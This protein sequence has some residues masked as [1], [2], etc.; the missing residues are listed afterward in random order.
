MEQGR[1]KDTEDKLLTSGATFNSTFNLQ[2]LPVHDISV[3]SSKIEQVF[4]SHPIG[5]SEILEFDIPISQTHYTN[6]SKS[7]LYLRLKA[8][9][10]DGKDLETDTK[11]SIGNMIFS[12]LFKNMELYV[13]NI[14]IS[15]ST[16]N[17]AFSSFIHRIITSTQA[18]KETKLK[19]ELY[20]P[21]TE[22]SP[23][24]ETNVMYKT[25]LAK[26]KTK[27]IELYSNLNHGL[28]ELK[29]ML[30][31]GV[32]VTIRLR[33]N[34]PKFCM[35]STEGTDALPF[36]DKIVIQEAFYDVH[37]CVANSKLMSLH[38][39][40]LSKNGKIHYPFRERDVI[41]FQVSKGSITYT[42]ETLLQR[43]PA[44]A[45]IAILKSDAYFGAEHLD[46]TQFFPHGLQ[47]ASLLI[48]GD[49]MMHQNFKFSVEDGQYV[50]LYRSLFNFTNSSNQAMNISEEE[51]TKNGLFLCPLYYTDDSFKDDR[52][53]PNVPGNVKVSLQFKS[54]LDDP[55]TVL[56]FYMYD[57]ILSLNKDHVFLD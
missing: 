10:H 39:S 54:A 31:P 34:S 15:S 56:F 22:P 16:N 5:N 21:S 12:T 11:T 30:V 51:F 14:L 1:Q 6:L 46:P 32:K 35:L 53:C 29:K 50:K 57:R 4:P 33:M 44:F 43:I 19:T 18:D 36:L 23:L 2:S 3:I 40:I 47:S 52:A 13:N 49:K 27:N 42:S 9:Q 8:T 38:D 20:I 17:Y 48:N 26:T 28:F 45:M 41:A 24:S 25:L 7:F 55:V 37:R